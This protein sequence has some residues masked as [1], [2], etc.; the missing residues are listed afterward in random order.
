MPT[1]GVLHRPGLTGEGILAEQR[2]DGACEP[3]G[4][5]QA[6]VQ[7]QTG[8]GVHAA[9]GIVGLVR[10]ERDAQQRNPVGQRRHHGVHPA[11]G[12]NQSRP[13]FQLGLWNIGFN[14][15]IWRNR[16]EKPGRTPQARPRQQEARAP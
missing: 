4:G 5:E 2:A 6:S 3:G 1:Q 15:H 8:P 7:A 11:V 13:G 16:R 12:D 10:A 9:L 14:A